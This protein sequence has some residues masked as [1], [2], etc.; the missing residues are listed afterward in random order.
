MTS[1]ILTLLVAGCLAAGPAA[2]RQQPSAQ[3][4]PQQQEEVVRVGTTAVQF[5]A[6]VTDKT[7]RRVTGLSA[8]DFQVTDD[9]KARPLDFFAAMEGSRLRPGAAGEAARAPETATP[10]TTPFEGRF[11]ALVFDDLN[12]SPDNFLRARNALADYIN[13]RLTP[14]DMVTVLP[15]SGVLGSLQ[16]LTNDKQRLLAALKRLNPRGAAGPRAGA[17]RFSMTVT[18]ALRIDAGD[19]ITLKQVRDRLAPDTGMIQDTLGGDVTRGNPSQRTEAAQEST[20]TEASR[21]SQIRTRAKGIVGELRQQTSNNLRTLEQIFRGMSDLPGRKI[22]VYLTESLVAAGGTSGDVNEQLNSLIETARRGGVSLY[23]VDATGVRGENITTAEERITA[24]ALQSRTTG[25]DTLS[26]DYEKLGAARAL[27]AGTGGELISN[28]NDIANGLQ[29]AVEDSSSYYILGFRPE[30]LDNKFH[31]LAV[32]VKGRPELV[33]RTRRGYLAVNPETSRGTPAELAAAIMSPVPLSELPVEVVARVV[34]QSGAQSVQLG[35]HV[36]RNYL[37][38]PAAG[39]ADQTASYELLA[40]VFAAGK[41]EPVGGVKRTLAFDLSKPEER[42]RF[43]TGGLVYVPQPLNLPPGQYQVRAVMR[44]KTSG[45]VGSAYQF[46][47]VPDTAD[48]KSV[49]ASSLLLS[50]AGKTEFA[51]ANSF[52]PGAEIDIRYVLY[53]LP[54]VTGDLTQGFRLVDAKGAVMF[55]SPLAI[56]PAAAG[57]TA[58][59]QGTRLKAPPRRGRYSLIL[60]LRD[61][62]GL[63]DLERR[64]DF[65]VE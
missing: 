59:S 62:K 16:Q 10:L 31:R 1:R 41:D 35:F 13:T 60:T 24:S 46:F 43:T 2:A 32:A 47:E 58:A 48:R 23:A 54:K 29:R 25:G 27:V 7:G 39:A 55:E 36:G 57:Q 18:E 51:G 37:S 19:E 63:V 20:I 30:A 3:P 56:A 34:P 12:L 44:E 22:V 21:D 64:A 26:A 5:E 8:S 40:A 50:E 11:I 53:N 33:V 45:A 17:D 38:L 6:I 9:G 14:T 28:S 15:T 42:Q 49:S 65:A 61:K 4:A 52:K